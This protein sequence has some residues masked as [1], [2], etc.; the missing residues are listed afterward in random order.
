M[1]PEPAQEAETPPSTLER[2]ILALDADQLN[3]LA[4]L[5][6]THHGKVRLAWH[7]SPDDQAATDDALRIRG[8]RDND[9]LP[10]LQLYAAG[11]QLSSLPASV[12]DLAPSVAGLNPRT[13]QG[14]TERVL[15]LLDRH[16]PFTLALYEAILRAADQRASGAATR[17]ELLSPEVAS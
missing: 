10:Q 11:A 6:C 1:P 8:I 3:L 14:W 5:V 17:D 16:G 15:S 12:L 13:G 7:A 9:S 4:Y 2:E